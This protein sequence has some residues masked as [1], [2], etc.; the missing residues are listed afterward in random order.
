MYPWIS[1]TFD[2]W[3][4]FC[5]KKCGIYM[6]VSGTLWMEAYAIP[7]QEATTVAR[8]LVEEFVFRHPEADPF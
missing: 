6:D 8:V 3:H 4:Q 5:E 1:C 7:N 2:F